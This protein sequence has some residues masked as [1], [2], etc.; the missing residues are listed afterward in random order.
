MFCSEKG[1]HLFSGESEDVIR[2]EIQEELEEM[3]KINAA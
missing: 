1:H 2:I 3:E